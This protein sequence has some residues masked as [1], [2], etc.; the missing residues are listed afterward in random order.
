MK[1]IR[2]QKLMGLYLET[3]NLFDLPGAINRLVYMPQRVSI[4]PLAGLT[5][6]VWHDLCMLVC[7]WTW[8]GLCI[9]GVSD[10]PGG[11]L[12]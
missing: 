2:R 4:R 7:G 3:K 5:P 1:L 9:A 8:H 6:T 12:P 11:D 10:M